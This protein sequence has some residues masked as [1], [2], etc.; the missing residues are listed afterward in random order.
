MK[1][2]V[3]AKINW[4]RLD[5]ERRLGLHS[6]KFTG[7]NFG[8]AFV[9]GLFLFTLFYAALFPFMGHGLDKIDMFFHGGANA[10]STINYYT[11]F[12]S[13]WALGALWIKWLKLKTQRVALT[14]NIL[15]ADPNFVLTATTAKEILDNIHNK[16]DD[17]KRFLLLDRI[18]RSL[19]NLKNLGNISDFA[20]GLK[21]QAEN[22]ESYVSATYT[23]IKSFIWGIP[24]LGFIG[25][26]VGLSSAVGDFGKIVSKG[27]DIEQLKSALGNVTSG[28]GTAFETTLIALVAA[29]I[30]QML[31]TVILHREEQ[32]LDECSDYCHK[33]LIAKMKVA[34]LQ[35]D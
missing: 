12:L 24:I 5:P 9:L 16:V 29:M 4:N 31:M 11:I 2:D 8:L 25:T 23:I 35:G 26:V 10:R 30:V 1:N 13:C 33:N 19:S 14:L 34:G 27:A 22:D 7:V 15:P 21:S 32:F 6:K 28:L 17:P 18:V 3:N 20:D